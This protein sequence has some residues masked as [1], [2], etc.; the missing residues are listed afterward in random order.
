MD[1]NPAQ[2]LGLAVLVAAALDYLVMWL[3]HKVE[4]AAGAF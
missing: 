3:W 4:S 2:F 1:S